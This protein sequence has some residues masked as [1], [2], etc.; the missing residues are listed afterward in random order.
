MIDPARS[1]SQDRGMRDAIRDLVLSETELETVLGAP[2]PRMRSK[3]RSTI[4]A[5]C[6]A[7]I[8]RCPF[9]L[10]ASA[11][12]E[13]RLDIS[14]KGDP[15]GFVTVIDETTLAIPDRP[16]NRRADTF[17]NLLRCDRVA[18]LF[19]IPGKGETLRASGT[20]V[21]ARDRWLLERMAVMGVV[22]ALA[23]VVTVHEIFFHCPRCIAR[24]ALWD[25]ASWPD[26]EAL[27]SLF[28]IETRNPLY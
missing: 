20:A 7:F 2:T 10:V 19:M 13:G 6:R 21:I 1:R 9:I 22:P 3:A 11:D 4:D 24:S 28:R 18:I 27:T 12:D 14:P 17:R 15:A 5:Q 26:A 8:E 25:T 23:L 16:G